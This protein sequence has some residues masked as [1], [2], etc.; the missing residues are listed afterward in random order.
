[1]TQPIVNA[2]DQSQRLAPE[3]VALRFGLPVE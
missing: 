1:M 2:R 3:R